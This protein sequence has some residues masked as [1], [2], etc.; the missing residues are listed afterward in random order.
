M[1]RLE[2]YNLTV[3]AVEL[4]GQHDFVCLSDVVH[5]ESV[6]EGC[7]YL[8]QRYCWFYLHR[9]V[10]QVSGGLLILVKK[11]LQRFVEVVRCHSKEGIL[12]LKIDRQFTCFEDDAFLF[13]CYFLPSTQ[14]TYRREGF[15]VEDCYLKLL[16]DLLEFSELG[17]I[18]GCGDLN[19]H[20]GDREDVSVF[21][22][23]ELEVAFPDTPPELFVD[24]TVLPRRS[25]QDKQ[26]VN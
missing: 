10:E 26:P 5:P 8:K 3:D 2:P 16:D 18:F 20:T 12:W 7:P 17:M 4:F 19:A 24:N 1:R 14:N 9:N 13:L 21:D 6:L 23:S 22:L 11:E 15:C 25:N